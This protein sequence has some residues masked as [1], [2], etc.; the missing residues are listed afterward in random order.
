[1]NISVNIVYLI[2]VLIYPFTPAVSKDIL[3]QLKVI[4]HTHKSLAKHIHV[5]MLH[6]KFELI[7]KLGIN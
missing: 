5:L 4:T 6:V 7:K 2:S 1:M 3:N